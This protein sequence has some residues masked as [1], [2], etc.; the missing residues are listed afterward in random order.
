ML[1]NGLSFCVPG[2]R[3]S[4]RAIGEIAFRPMSDASPPAAAGTPSSDAAAPAPSAPVS[5]AR[6][7]S[8][9]TVRVQQLMEERKQI[10]SHKKVCA[11]ELKSRLRK[12]KKRVSG[13]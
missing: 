13:T 11:K 3:T 7:S 6:H 4:L 5:G 10:L 9:P 1:S 12:L 8:S 2:S